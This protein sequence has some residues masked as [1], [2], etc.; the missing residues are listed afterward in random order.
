MSATNELLVLIE[1]PI[2]L[3]K[4]DTDKVLYSPATTAAL[5]QIDQAR[6]VTRNTISGVAMRGLRSPASP[7]YPR[8]DTTH[9]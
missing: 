8:Q 6:D 4:S 5:Q 7:Y 1:I 9:V 2:S 3:T